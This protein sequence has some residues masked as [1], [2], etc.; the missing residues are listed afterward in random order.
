MEPKNVWKTVFA[1]IY[2]TFVSHTMQQG[3]CNTSATFQWLMTVIFRDYI[4]RFVHVYLDDIFV[5]SNSIEEH[6]KHL[7]LV[8]DKLHQAY[9]Y[10]EESKL[11]LYSKRMDCL[12]HLIDDRGIHAD[13]DKMSRI[14]GWRTPRNK[15]DVQRFL[16]LVQ[17]LAHF[18]P[19]VSAY[20]GPLAAIQKNSHLFLWKPCIKYA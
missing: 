18:M 5:Y 14:C 17:Y 2:G 3:D 15:H 9:L 6:E 16:G 11:D 12:G 20:T 1:T 10:L 4:R 19:D 7:E 8:F 13:S